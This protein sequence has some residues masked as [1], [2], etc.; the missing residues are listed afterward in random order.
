MN[1]TQSPFLPH[2]TIELIT[3]RVQFAA[4]R[5]MLMVMGIKFIESP[6][7]RPLVHE[8]EISRHALSGP[9]R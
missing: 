1:E 4:Q 8:E 7:G 5:R 3:G 2:K 6:N 9:T